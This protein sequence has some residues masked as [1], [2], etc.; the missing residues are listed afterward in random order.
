MKKN[1]KTK[2]SL[3]R[4]KIKNI[5]SKFLFIILIILIN[6]SICAYYYLEN[7]LGDVS[8]FQF[9]YHIMTGGS[10][11]GTFTVIFN[12][13]KSCIP[14]IIVL[15]II[16]IFLFTRWKKYK[17]FFK[18]KR[19]NKEY[20]IFPTVLSKYRL[21]SSLI[22][23]S[24]CVITFLNYLKFLEYLDTQNSK[25]DIYE[26]YY[27]DSNKVNISFNG[28][29][30]NLIYIYLESMES[31]LF[32][33]KNNGYFEKS[34]IPE[35]EKLAEKNINFSQNSG[36][37]GM[38]DVD[39]YTIS[40]LVSSTSAT[41]IESSC[42]NKCDNI[43]GKVRTL[44]DVLK[45]EGYNVYKTGKTSTTQVTTIIN[46]ANLSEETTSNLKSTLGTGVISSSSRASKVDVTIILGKDYK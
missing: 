21:I 22:I 7:Y 2:K 1:K 29:K 33:K 37:G 19:T 25:T 23:L 46:K 15:I 38:Y 39:G 8:F 35:L 17:L 43:V 4:Q 27:I 12:A 28:K 16:E 36:L 40:A 11:S 10:D 24:I 45:N 26:K 13:F 32:S 18:S 3:K 30:R 44:G 5:I 34:R 31:S 42:K 14:I 6:I 20:C 9:Y 41:P